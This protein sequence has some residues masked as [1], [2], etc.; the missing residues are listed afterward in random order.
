MTSY[1]D[2]SYD[3]NNLSINLLDH[4]HNLDKRKNPTVNL[5]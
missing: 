1:I 5:F 2:I 3:N 4:N